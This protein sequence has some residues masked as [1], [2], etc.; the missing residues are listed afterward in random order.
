ML[1]AT[2]LGRLARDGHFKGY[3]LGELL[4]MS[5]LSTALEHSRNVASCAVVVDA[6]NE[7]AKDFYVSFGFIHL[8]AGHM[9]RLFLPMRTVEDMFAGTEATK[10]NHTPE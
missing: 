10:A 3:G 7:K 6:K 4:L 5:A 8:P 1:P 9:N 2:L